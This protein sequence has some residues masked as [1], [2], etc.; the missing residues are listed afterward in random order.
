MRL[1]HFQKVKSG[2][3]KFESVAESIFKN[4]VLK[5]QWRLSRL[6]CI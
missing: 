1:I 4:D 3:E 2:I 5:R 6:D